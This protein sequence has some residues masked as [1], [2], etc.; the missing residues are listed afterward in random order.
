MLRKLLRIILGTCKDN[1]LLSYNKQC[2]DCYI[3]VEPYLC[4]VEIGLKS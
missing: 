3:V 2:D 4:D 1:K